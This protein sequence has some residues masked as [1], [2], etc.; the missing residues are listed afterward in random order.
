MRT[1][2]IYDM[3]R[4][5]I[6]QE[7]RRN[8]QLLSLPQ[9]LSEVLEEVGKEDFSS[10]QLAR[11]ILKDPPLTGRILR[12]ANSSFYHQMNEIKT[13]HQAINILG[14]TTVKCLALSTSV[15]QPSRVASA[16]GVDSKA[17]FTYIL[18][19]AGA[20]EKIARLVGY[21]SPEEAFIAGLLHDIG[22][23]YLIHHYPNEYHKITSGQ[24]K[25]PSLSDAETKVF[26]IDHCEV[27]QNVATTWS[28]P[29]YIVS[30]IAGHHSY[31]GLK[32]GDTLQDCVR[33]AVVLSKD[34]FSGFRDSI[35]ERINARQVLAGLLGLTDEDMD[36]ITSTILS[37]TIDAAGY[38]DVDIGDIDEILIS[39]NR[40]I[41]KSYLTI[42]NLFK[43]RQEL[44]RKLLLQ[45][46]EKGA[47]ESRNV[48][49]ATLSHYLNNAVMAAYGRS[50]IMRRQLALG[51][52]DKLL[53]QMPHNL[54]A[55]DDTVKKVVA[56]LKEM[57]EIS[58]IDQERFMD[59][60]DSLDIDDLIEKRLNQMAA[61][62]KWQAPPEPVAS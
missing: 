39:A 49:M 5:S 42:E 62:D 7:I 44:S 12:L 40:E 46:R 30:S 26:G 14:M 60:F 56:V 25:A 23:L 9:V 20:S 33:L 38:L 45:E 27:G 54:D 16:S 32:P 8:D 34:E 13:V 15:F 19:V 10:E 59:M 43:D 3:D 55:I 57:Q 31:L 22:V 18:S 48:A 53:E 1:R 2:E 50:Q 24:I 11:I 52:T 47:I 17:F 51:Q 28:L 21:P 41:W 36:E 35:E 61:E 6:I 58:P 29:E 37:V 4:L